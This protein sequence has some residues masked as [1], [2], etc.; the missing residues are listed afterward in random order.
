MER[1]EFE[2][3]LKI[4]ISDHMPLR[5]KPDELLQAKLL[6]VSQMNE[7]R[8]LQAKLAAAEKRVKELEYVMGH[9]MRRSG[10]V[11]NDTV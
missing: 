11:A 8:S 3:K 1:D 9:A 4:I 5:H 10:S 7:I 6:G 2:S